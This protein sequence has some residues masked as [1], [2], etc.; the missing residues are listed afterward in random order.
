MKSEILNTKLDFKYLQ[1]KPDNEVTKSEYQTKF[2]R[3]PVLDY[4]QVFE[5]AVLLTFR[6]IIRNTAKL[7]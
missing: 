6:F 3:S 5:N 4:M 7:D 2:Q 1:F